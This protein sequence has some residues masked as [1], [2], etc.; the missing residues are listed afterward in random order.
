MPRPRA[1]RP[2]RVRRRLT[3]FCRGGE[4]PS[5]V[6]RGRRS[7]VA[8]RAAQSCSNWAR[9]TERVDQTAMLKDLQ[10]KL[11]ASKRARRN[12]RSGINREHKRLRTVCEAPRGPRRRL[13]RAAGSASTPLDTACVVPVD[14]RRPTP[15]C[16][17]RTSIVLVNET[18]MPEYPTNCPRFSVRPSATKW[19]VGV[20]P[21]WSGKPIDAED[22]TM[23]HPP[24]GA[25]SDPQTVFRALFE[26]SAGAAPRA[27]ADRFSAVKT[28]P[29]TRT[30]AVGTVRDGSRRA[31]R[32]AGRPKR[33]C[34]TAYLLAVSEVVPLDRCGHRRTRRCAPNGA[35]CRGGLLA[36]LLLGADRCACPRYSLRV[37]RGAHYAV[38]SGWSKSKRGPT[39]RRGRRR[40]PVAGARRE[41]VRRWSA[42]WTERKE[43]RGASDGEGCSEGVHLRRTVRLVDS[44]NA[45][46]HRAGYRSQ[47]GLAYPVRPLP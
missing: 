1:T 37:A 22:T 7:R 8:V 2:R 42:R 33:A 45:G 39:T 14:G 19:L 23:S 30:G 13:A 9:L 36:R 5:E 31:T 18:K 3:A 12:R 26:S 16:T 17:R 4:N 29:V 34:E 40:R 20:A 43:R 44:P 24:A 6:A 21:G 25:E 35:S 28:A 32:A 41:R 15:A 38:A 11:D 10:D 46:S 27:P 47:Y